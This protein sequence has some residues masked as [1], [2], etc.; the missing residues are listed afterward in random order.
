[1]RRKI[2]Y[3]LMLVLGGTAVFNKRSRGEPMRWDMIKAFDSYCRIY[4][5]MLHFHT[6][7]LCQSSDGVFTL[8]TGFVLAV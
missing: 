6:V 7:I 2:T 4:A 3:I 1:M 8:E 5:T